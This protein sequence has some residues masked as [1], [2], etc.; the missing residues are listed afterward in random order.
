L[1]R[2]SADAELRRARSP[3]EVASQLSR[4]YGHEFPN[5]SYQQALALV[6]RAR[7]ANLTGDEAETRD[8]RQLAEAVPDGKKLRGSTV[9]GYLIFA[10][11]G[12]TERLIYAA[13]EAPDHNEMSDGVFMGCPLLAAAGKPDA[14]LEH[15]RDVQRLCLRDDGIY[16]HSPLH[17]AAWGRGNGFPALGLAWTLDYLP[18]DFFGRGE[19]LTSFRNHLAALSS[20]QAENGMWHQVIDHP[21]SYA[22][23]SGTCMITYAMI[24]GLRHGWLDPATYEPIVDL[25]WEAIKLRIALDGEH[26]TDVCEGTGKQSSLEAYFQRRAI[27]GRD[28]RGGAMALLVATER[29][30]WEGERSSV[31]AQE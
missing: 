2:A 25:A 1:A 9:A 7:L 30:L 31:P 26:L 24:H 10:E 17:E 18:E 27:Q 8:V 28:E 16:R 13:A 11:L 6:G 22:E 19:V 29:A 14:C 12:M 15:L 5:V 4:N 21:D 20:H 3:L 23:L